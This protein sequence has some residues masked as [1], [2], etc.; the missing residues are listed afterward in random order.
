MGDSLIKMCK[1]YEQVH[2]VIT[3][4]DQVTWAHH[5]HFSCDMNIQSSC[6]DPTGECVI[7]VH[8][9]TIWKNFTIKRES[10][11]F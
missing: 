8:D 1:S 6:G 5:L 10:F 3:E 4:K 9:A 2:V 11:V 7:L